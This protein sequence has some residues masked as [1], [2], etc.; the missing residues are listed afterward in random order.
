MNPTHHTNHLLRQPTNYRPLLAAV[1][2]LLAFVMLA[3]YVDLLYS[4][5]E[6]GK[7]MRAVNRAQV[8]A[9]AQPPVRSELMAS[10]EVKA[11]SAQDQRTARLR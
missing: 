9:A 6:R 1:A 3:V 10:A 8:L 11:G 4:Q 7:A 5:V 2:A